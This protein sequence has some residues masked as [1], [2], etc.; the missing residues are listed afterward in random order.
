M[1]LSLLFPA[2]LWYSLV[3]LQGKCFWYRKNESR[4]KV[5]D[6]RLMEITVVIV[7]FLGGWFMIL[8][9]GLKKRGGQE[10]GDWRIIV[11]LLF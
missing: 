2:V 8:S 4:C 5:N 6:S 11:P 7:V 10:R 1:K 3:C 9:R